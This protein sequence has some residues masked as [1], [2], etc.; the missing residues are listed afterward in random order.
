[1]SLCSLRHFTSQHQQKDPNAPRCFSCS[2]TEPEH[3]VC[4]TVVYSRQIVAA[5]SNPQTSS[6]HLFSW[7]CRAVPLLC[8]KAQLKSGFRAGRRVELWAGWTMMW[9]FD[10]CTL[11]E[12]V[13][14]LFF[15]GW[16]GGESVAGSGK[17][18][19]A[20]GYPLPITSTLSSSPFVLGSRI[21][22]SPGSDRFVVSH[23]R[24]KT[25]GRT[26]VGNQLGPLL[27]TEIRGGWKAALLSLF[28]LACCS[29]DKTVKITGWQQRASL[30][31]SFSSKLHS[32]S[33][34][35]GNTEAEAPFKQHWKGWF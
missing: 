30:W 35:H 23:S 11:R 28:L 13:F 1:M 27:R 20:V 17:L 24:G 33:C 4:Q 9:S 7:W 29:S 16:G 15:L 21:G 10:L 5:L 31:L 25:Q 12:F 14:V 22:G 2:W 3:Q 18:S 32:W 26:R 34:Y 6:A 8:S 19:P